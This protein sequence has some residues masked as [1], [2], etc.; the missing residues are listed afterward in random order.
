[1]EK[2]KLI[3]KDGQPQTL[4]DRNFSLVDD[5]VKIANANNS[6]MLMAFSVLPNNDIAVYSPKEMTREAKIQIFEY[7]LK[8]YRG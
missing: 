3:G 1:M 2:F 7:L 8:K 5:W 6:G 4:Q